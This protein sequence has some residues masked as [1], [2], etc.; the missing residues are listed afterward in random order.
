MKIHASSTPR[1][2]NHDSD[3]GYT[4]LNALDSL[5]RQRTPTRRVQKPQ[6]PRPH[7]ISSCGIS[8]SDSNADD[9]TIV[10]GRTSQPC[11]NNRMYRLK[12]KSNSSNTTK[13]FLG[14]KRLVRKY[15]MRQKGE[16]EKSA[17]YE[18][19]CPESEDSKTQPLEHKHRSGRRNRGSP[20]KSPCRLV[21]MLV[22]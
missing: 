13:E 5:K 15:R 11:N 20:C 12:L 1:L 19:I 9:E 4:S 16:D 2:D 14:N 21:T 10:Y 22:V 8:D 18:R 6:R 3:D 17:S 7:S